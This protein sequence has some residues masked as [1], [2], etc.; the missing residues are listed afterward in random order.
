MRQ[1]TCHLFDRH[2][3]H[4]LHDLLHDA[5]CLLVDACRGCQDPMQEFWPPGGP[6]PQVTLKRMEVDDYDESDDD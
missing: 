2:D 1:C 4:D 3:V 6:Q 5:N